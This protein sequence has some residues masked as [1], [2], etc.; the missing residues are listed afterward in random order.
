LLATLGPLTA[1]G[2]WTALHGS[3]GNWIY[4]S[5]ALPQGWAMWVM[6]YTLLRPELV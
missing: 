4:L 3:A 1:L 5:L 6:T 2:R